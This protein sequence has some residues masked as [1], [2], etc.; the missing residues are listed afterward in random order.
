MLNFSSDRAGR[1]VVDE[2]VSPELPVKSNDYLNVLK[3]FKRQIF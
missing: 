3:F 2:K 1:D